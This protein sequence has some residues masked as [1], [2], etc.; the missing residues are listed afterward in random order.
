M[1]RT[2]DPRPKIVLACSVCQHRNYT[3]TKN[4]RN[5]PGRLELRKY[6]P[7]CGRTTVHRETR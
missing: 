7:T 4:R 3:T 6:C 5:S 2:G 1:A